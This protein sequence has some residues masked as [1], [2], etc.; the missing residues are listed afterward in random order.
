[1]LASRERHSPD[2]MAALHA[3][4][5]SGLADELLPIALGETLA[6]ADAVAARELLAG[7]DRRMDATSAAAAMFALWLDALAEELFRT[8]L[9]DALYDLYHTNRSWIS[10]FATEAAMA[11]VARRP[12]RARVI[13]ASLAAA[14]R[15]ARERLGDDPSLWR[16]GTLH[17]ITFA[18]VLGRALPPLADLFN[19]GPYEANGGDDTVNRGT[20]TIGENFQ[21]GGIP[22]YRQIVD[23]GDFDRSRSVITTGC[24]G[25]PASPYY[26]NQAQLWL[27]GEYHPMLFSPEAIA[28]EAA[29]TLTIKPA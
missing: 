25:N 11:H 18:H 13:E 5:K 19:A 16:W 26:A 17:R 22:S 21:T 23:L 28:A 20:Y 6:D 4:T 2:D 14:Y 27:H 7:W 15:H 1:V 8:E 29:G 12:D 3:D 9:G 24:S 10:A